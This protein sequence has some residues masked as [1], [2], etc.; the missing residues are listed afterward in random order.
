MLSLP[1]PWEIVTADVSLGDNAGAW[2]SGRGGGWEIKNARCREI[3]MRAVGSV[4]GSWKRG[5]LRSYMYGG[6]TDLMSVGYDPR[7]GPTT[8]FTFFRDPPR[9]DPGASVTIPCALP[10]WQWVVPTRHLFCFLYIPSTVCLFLKIKF[11]IGGCTRRWLL[12]R[13][14]INGVKVFDQ[15]S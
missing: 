13:Y 9:H 10:N 7:A 5:V 6:T 14:L 15:F 2:V 3:R 11:V 4:V 12:N 1:L 8:G